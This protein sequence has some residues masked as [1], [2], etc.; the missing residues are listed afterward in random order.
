MQSLELLDNARAKL[1][2]GHIHDLGGFHW[3]PEIKKAAR[4]R[5]LVDVVAALGVL[6]ESVALISDLL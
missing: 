6:S 1:V 2:F 4:R 5:L 3:A